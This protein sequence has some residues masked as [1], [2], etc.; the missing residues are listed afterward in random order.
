MTT[1]TQSFVKILQTAMASPGKLEFQK[2][3]TLS[4]VREAAVLFQALRGVK[5]EE[6][7]TD[8][9]FI[10][11]DTEYF[12]EELEK[13]PSLVSTFPDCLSFLLDYSDI[14]PLFQ[15]ML[16]LTYA[17]IF[18]HFKK[19]LIE[20]SLKFDFTQFEKEISYQE[21]VLL[22]CL[23][24]IKKNEVLGF[25]PKRKSY[26]ILG[27]LLDE[28]ITETVS[29]VLSLKDIYIKEIQLLKHFF[30][31]IFDSKEIFEGD[32]PI[33]YCKEWEKLEALLEIIEGKLIDIVTSFERKRFLNLFTARQLRKLIK[34]LFIDSD[35][36]K[37]AL[38]VII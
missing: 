1:N 37:N 32:S 27:K 30:D 7:L 2:I 34:A 16:E 5:K 3:S 23:K 18:D 14:I 21:A 25:F 33:D 9:M 10:C 20:K 35:K 11:S 31:K 6:N 38:K 12:L 19:L 17:T 8:L 26:L 15:P 29:R 28:L 24:L 13:F 22:S 4:S 36:R